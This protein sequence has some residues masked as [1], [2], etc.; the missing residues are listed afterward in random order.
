MLMILVTAISVERVIDNNE[1]FKLIATQHNAKTELI[2]VMCKAA[3]ERLITLPRM[4]NMEDPFDREEQFDCFNE[5]ATR[6][7]TA[8]IAV[9]SKVFDEKEQTLFEQLTYGCPHVHKVENW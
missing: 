1:R 4:V 8:H 5:L 2:M 6:L 7:P 9:I 3:R